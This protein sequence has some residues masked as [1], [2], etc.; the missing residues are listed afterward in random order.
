MSLSSPEQVVDLF[1]Q[2]I[3]L[4]NGNIQS[5][6]FQI[7]KNQI[8]DF[9]SNFEQ[10]IIFERSADIILAL[11]NK[12]FPQMFGLRDTSFLSIVMQESDTYQSSIDLTSLPMTLKSMLEQRVLDVKNSK[13]VNITLKENFL[14]R[15]FSLVRNQ[16]SNF[17]WKN[18]FFA[19]LDS[20]FEK[21]LVKEP[22]F[23]PILLNLFEHFF[24]FELEY[25]VTAGKFPTLV[26]PIINQLTLNDSFFTLLAIYCSQYKHY[27]REELG[28]KARKDKQLYTQFKHHNKTMSKLVELLFKICEN[29]A[30]VSIPQINPVLLEFF[31]SLAGSDSF[32]ALLRENSQTTFYALV[33]KYI[34]N[35]ESNSITSEKELEDFQRLITSMITFT[36]V[37]ESFKKENSKFLENLKKKVPEIIVNCGLYV[38]G[39][40]A[41]KSMGVLCSALRITDIEREIQN[42]ESVV[43]N[44]NKSRMSGDLDERIEPNTK[45]K[46]LNAWEYPFNSKKEFMSLFTICY[47]LSFL[48]DRICFWRR[49]SF[50]KESEIFI[51]RNNELVKLR[52]TKSVPITNLRWLSQKSTC[53]TLVVILII[54]KL[55]LYFFS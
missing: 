55:F 42:L 37:S 46:A 8:D 27:L 6:Y 34:E 48:I 31:E 33:D 16:L 47:Y 13:K 39:A 9:F 5:N 43:Y 20:I 38:D 32:S 50:K 14:I 54:L 24:V 40:V 2:K 45:A 15:F 44:R 21:V 26:S 11:Q 12:Y 1:L 7:A 3:N 19:A 35:I 36:E 29:S 4:A 28:K 25:L 51:Y 17:W 18:F 49:G 23:S 41:K 30:K 53:V 10:L 52:K 22:L